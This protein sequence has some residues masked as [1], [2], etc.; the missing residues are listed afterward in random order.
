MQTY[1][2]A[3]TISKIFPASR[4][5]HVTIMVRPSNCPHEIRVSITPEKA[6]YIA[7][8]EVGSI[9]SVLGTPVYLSTNQGLVLEFVKV[10]YISRILPAPQTQSSIES[11]HS[12]VQS[13]GSSLQPV[14]ETVSYP[15]A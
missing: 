10:A 6:Y 5:G 4:N 12:P 1:S 8:S 7:E 13:G 3:G 2:I 9:V 14:L 11:T 15:E